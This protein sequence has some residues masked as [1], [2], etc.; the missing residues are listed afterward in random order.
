MKLG[1]KRTCL[2][3]SWMPVVIAALAF[4][5]TIVM[6]S[7]A[8]AYVDQLGGGGGTALYAPYTVLPAEEYAP[9]TAGPVVSEIQLYAPYAAGPVIHASD[10]YAPYTVLPV[11]GEAGVRIGNY[12]VW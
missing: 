6:A 10:V 11:G 5:L 1:G 12:L 2:T 8:Y 7:V 3:R 4:A 9:Y